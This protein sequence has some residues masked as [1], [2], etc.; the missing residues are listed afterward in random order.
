MARSPLFVS[1]IFNE[2][3]IEVKRTRKNIKK[4]RNFFKKDIDKGEVICYNIM[5]CEWGIAKR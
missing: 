5:R 1:Y 3:G 2:N 4:E